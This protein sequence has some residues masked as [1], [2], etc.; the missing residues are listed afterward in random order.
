MYK[1]RFDVET[2]SKATRGVGLVLILTLRF[3]VET[4][5]KATKQHRDMV[6]NMLRFDVETISKATPA[7]TRLPAVSCGLM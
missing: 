3:D 2:I 5:S 6:E 7:V 4:I 1:L